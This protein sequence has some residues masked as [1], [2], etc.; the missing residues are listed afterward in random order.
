M[1]FT[2]RNAVS[3]AW[4]SLALGC[5]WLQL[6]MPIKAIVVHM[7]TKV[8][9]HMLH[10]HLRD[11]EEFQCEAKI[12]SWVWEAFDNY[13]TT[14][15]MRPTPVLILRMKNSS[16]STTHCNIRLYHTWHRQQRG[17]NFIWIATSLKYGLPSRS[18]W[19]NFSGYYLAAV[20]II[21]GEIHVP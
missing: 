11:R 8:V 2:Q 21:Q 3:V 19:V 10:R 14:I 5:Q 1:F 20:D 4:L 15:S 12:P 13:I 16:Y 18:I 17:G 6:L 9:L 7:V